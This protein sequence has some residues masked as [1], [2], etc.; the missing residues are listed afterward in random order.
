MPT[1]SPLLAL[2]VAPPAAS[3]RQP[4]PL[5][6]RAVLVGGATASVAALLGPRSA[7]ADLADLDMEGTAPTAMAP[8]AAS[9]KLDVVTLSGTGATDK[10]S[11]MSKPAARL[12]ELTERN[13]R[14]E[15]SEKE[16]KELRKLKADEMCEMLGRGC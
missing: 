6:R 3:A 8:V 10:A 9:P 4:P 16:K 7:L 14:G 11:R 12:K 13:A 15:L 1:K 2:A 5:P